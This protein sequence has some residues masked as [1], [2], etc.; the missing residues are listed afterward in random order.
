[1]ASPIRLVISNRYLLDIGTVTFFAFFF[2][3]I[4]MQSS[5]LK[6]SLQMLQVKKQSPYVSTPSRL[7]VANH[8]TIKT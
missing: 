5:H 6:L 1:M 8:P 3:E 7:R 2:G 4:Q